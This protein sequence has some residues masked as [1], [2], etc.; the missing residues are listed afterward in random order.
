MWLWTPLRL[1]RYSGNNPF[2]ESQ[3]KKW[4][5]LIYL[6][7]YIHVETH[8]DPL[9]NNTQL[10]SCRELIIRI[11]MTLDIV[12]NTSLELFDLEWVFKLASA[13]DVRIYGIY[14]YI[15]ITHALQWAAAA[16]CDLVFT[17]DGLKFTFDLSLPGKR[18]SR[19]SPN[20]RKVRKK[21]SKTISK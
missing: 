11:K 1:P 10:S 7:H 17:G 12:P 15:W 20:P 6:I 3:R 4:F 5:V 13:C 8:H 2:K 16:D 19:K 14:L 18:S 21:K 9:H